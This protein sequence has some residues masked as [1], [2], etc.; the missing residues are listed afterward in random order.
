MGSKY[1]PVPHNHSE[2]GAGKEDLDDAEVTPSV[3]GHDAQWAWHVDFFKLYVIAK[4]NFP[5]LG[6]E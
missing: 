4:I 6:N 1:I 2:Q 3:G 5:S